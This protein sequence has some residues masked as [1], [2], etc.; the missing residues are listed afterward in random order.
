MPKMSA[1]GLLIVAVGFVSSTRTGIVAEVKVLLASSVVTT[2]RS[3]CR[4]ACAVV[5]E[6]AVWLSRC[7]RDRR[8]LELDGREARAGVGGSLVRPIVPRT[9]ARQPEQ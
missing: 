3:Y 6:L 2:R 9:L 8:A 7:P 1:P 5:S 4:S